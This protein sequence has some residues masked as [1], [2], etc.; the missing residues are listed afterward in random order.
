MSEKNRKRKTDLSDSGT[1]LSAR[2][3]WVSK[4]LYDAMHEIRKKKGLNLSSVVEELI[5]TGL[6][7]RNMSGSQVIQCNSCVL[8]DRG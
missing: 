5:E 3:V 4:T 6:R 1:D 2:P 8:S 7:C